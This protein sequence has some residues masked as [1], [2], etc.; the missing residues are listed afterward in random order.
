[1]PTFY[2]YKYDQDKKDHKD[3][4]GFDDPDKGPIAE[5]VGELIG[6]SS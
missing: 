1:M 6:L 2:I 4:I 5:K 3:K